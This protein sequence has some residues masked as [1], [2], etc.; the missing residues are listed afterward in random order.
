VGRMEG[1]VA[2]VTGAARGIGRGCAE[3]LAREG[4]RVVIGDVRAAEGEEAA[5][6]DE[7]VGPLGLGGDEGQGEPAL[8]AEAGRLGREHPEP[9]VEQFLRIGRVEGDRLDLGR[10]RV[11]PGGPLLGREESQPPP[12]RLLSTVAARSMPRGRG[13]P[14]FQRRWPASPA[15]HPHLHADI[16]VHQILELAI[17]P[18]Q[19]REHTRH[20]AGTQLRDHCHDNRQ[21]EIG[22][23]ACP[24]GH[25]QSDVQGSRGR[26][27]VYPSLLASGINPGDRARRAILMQGGRRLHCPASEEGR[28]R[29]YTGP[30]RTRD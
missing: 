7:L 11:R 26:K 17:R 14:R 2:V 10:D 13:V 15:A 28:T 30:L 22:V 27:S 21:T 16:V 23:I 5:E 19:A 3:T 1:K 9:L 6:G 29:R 24:S 8:G 12:P 4:A 25:D 20:V 18:E